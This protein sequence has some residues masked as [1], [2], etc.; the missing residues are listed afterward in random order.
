VIGLDCEWRPS[1]IPGSSK[2]LVSLM[3]ISWGREALLVHMLKL[4]SIPVSL[5]AFLACPD[6]LKVGVGVV[7]DATRLGTD[8]GLTVRG[9][10]DVAECHILATRASSTVVPVA[11]R[12]FGRALPEDSWDSNE[13]YRRVFQDAD[14]AAPEGLL[15][16]AV[17]RSAAME[18]VEG[19]RK[20]SALSLKNLAK[21]YTGV[22][23]WKSK[24]TTMSNWE[25]YPLRTRQIEYAALDAWAGAAIADALYGRGILD[26]GLG[27]ALS[28]NTEAPARVSSTPAEP[29]QDEEEE[30]EAEASNDD[31][32]APTPSKDDAAAAPAAK[33]K[34]AAAKGKDAAAKGKDAAAKGKG[35]RRGGQSR[36]GRAGR[37]RG[38]RGSRPA[39]KAELAARAFRVTE[40]FLSG[41]I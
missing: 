35:P 26:R 28:C 11:S 12:T 24:K 31:V 10:V 13:G 40:S 17:L 38:G 16:S 1:V 37:G 3:Q 21:G 5:R 41:A 7:D 29:E 14:L 8:H 6:V 9:V 36:G 20:F 23:S 25:Q 39:T 32:A 27:G 15:S 30:Q 19:G 22:E 33:G 18:F 34:D 4:D 2:Q